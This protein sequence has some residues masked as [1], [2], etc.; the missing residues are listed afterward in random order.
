MKYKI[1]K[2]TVQETLII[3]LYARKICS[4]IYKNI[5]QDK[6]A[7]LLIDKIDYD[8]SLIEKK[9]LSFIERF[10]FLEV[11]VRQYDL[12]TEIK[13]YIKKHPECS[14]VN[15]G[16]GL[17]NSARLCD[18]GRIKIYNI[19]FPDVIELRNKLLPPEEREENIPSD[20]N[21]TEW[22]DKI[23]SSSGIIFFAS[24]VFYY[25]LKEQ[26][27]SLVCNLESRFPGS[28]LIFDGA[29]SFAVKTITK[30]WLKKAEIKNVGAYFS[31]SNAKKE[32]SPWSNKIDVLSKGYMLGYNNLKDP[33]VS[34]F[35]RFLA[36]VGDKV[37]KMQ[38]VKITFK[39]GV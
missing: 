19:D 9:K 17:D 6:T 33:S 24:G 7:S 21:N 18:N 8:F 10:G 34:S 38:I 31:V 27:K 23:D 20:L 26:V 3:P 14:V 37:M 28:V 2:N 15:L 39:E 36:K 12:T 30:T 13:E 29:N 35:S 1:E 22:M 5:Y 25:F 4:E 32:I 16:C 11:A